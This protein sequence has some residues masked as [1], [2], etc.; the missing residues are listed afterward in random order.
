MAFYGK[1]SGFCTRVALFET[2]T[3]EERLQQPEA[4]FG[5]QSAR[6]L[7]LALEGIIRNHVD[8]RTTATETGVR[9]TVDHARNTAVEDSASTHRARFK[10]YI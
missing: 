9:G 6:H 1:K 8:S 4:L 3:L 10:R 2:H 7:D 5:E